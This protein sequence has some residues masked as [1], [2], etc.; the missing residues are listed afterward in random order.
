MANDVEHCFICLWALSMSSLEK[1]LFRSFAHFLIGLF[2]FL[3]L[4]HMY[5]YI[6]WKLNLC[7]MYHWQICSSIQSVPSSF[8]CWFLQLCRCILISCSPIFFFI[9]LDLGDMSVKILLN[10]KSEILLPMFSSRTFM[11]PRLIFKS[12]I[13]FQFILVCGISWWSSFISVHVPVLFSQHHLLKRL[14]LLHCMLVPPL[15][16]INWP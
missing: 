1:C 4:S 8:W 7:P 6:F 15:S 13:H 2:V 3:V 14:F 16:N 11:V 9:S 12:F 5:S 10:G